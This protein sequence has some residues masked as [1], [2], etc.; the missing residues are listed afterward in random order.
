MKLQ[1]RIKKLEQEA[2]NKIKQIEE[3]TLVIVKKRLEIEEAL[4]LKK[5]EEELLKLQMLVY[6]E[7]VCHSDNTLAKGIAEKELEWENEATETGL[8]DEQKEEIKDLYRKG[9]SEEKINKL[10]KDAKFRFKALDYEKIYNLQNYTTSSLKIN[11]PLHIETETG[12]F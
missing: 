2:I 10:F 4:V 5:Q 6:K 8:T 12:D 7:E 1:D 9:V 11:K 3:E